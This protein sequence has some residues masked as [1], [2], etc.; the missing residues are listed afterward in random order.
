MCVVVVNGD[1]G[2]S[3]PL[4]LLLPVRLGWVGY[5]QSASVSPEA[6]ARPSTSFQTFHFAEGHEPPQNESHSKTEGRRDSDNT[7]MQQPPFKTQ[8]LLNVHLINVQ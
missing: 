8:T 3:R 1:G 4:F 6:D 2:S 7:G 5:R